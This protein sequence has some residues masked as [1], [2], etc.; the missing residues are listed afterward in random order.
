MTERMIYPDTPCGICR[1]PNAV[2]NPEDLCAKCQQGE[3]E[4]ANEI[5]AILYGRTMNGHKWL[6]NG[7]M[8]RN[9]T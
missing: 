4:T 6:N 5:R 1:K 2:Y 9:H 3:A 8:K 7:L